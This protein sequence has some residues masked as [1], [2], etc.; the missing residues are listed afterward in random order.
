MDCGG[1]VVRQLFE[2]HHYFHHLSLAG[3]VAAAIAQALAPIE[4]AESSWLAP[5]D[6]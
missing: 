6:S 5:M 4:Q 1:V 2:E 3:P